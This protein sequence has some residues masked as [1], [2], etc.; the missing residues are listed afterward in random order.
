MVRK[1]NTKKRRGLSIAEVLITL[2]FIAVVVGGVVQFL[3]AYWKARASEHITASN[4]MRYESSP[5]QPEMLKAVRLNA[6]L[7]DSLD[8]A[9][10]IYLFGG[11]GQDWQDATMSLDSTINLPA[12][13]FFDRQLGE[14]TAPFLPANA[15][16][17]VGAA[18]HFGLTNDGTGPAQARR[19]GN[20]TLI[21]Y[22]RDHA[23][24]AILEVR[25]ERTTDSA[26]GSWSI[27][28]ARLLK[29]TGDSTNPTAEYAYG[30]ALRTEKAN[31]SESPQAT[32]S[33]RGIPGADGTSRFNAPIYR[34]SL[35]DPSLEEGAAANPRPYFNHVYSGSGSN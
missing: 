10:E 28:R 12:E 34:F 21:A 23:I 32:T 33:W 25:S 30:A 2:M 29:L 13:G 5:S 4:G 7:A 27:W 20:Y 17:P 24:S 35:P 8:D 3:S 16:S 26:G 22:G 1:S 9:S 11:R 6:A 15:M 14:Q 18:A 31:L 19:D